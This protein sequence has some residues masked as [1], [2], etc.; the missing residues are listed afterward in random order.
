MV[1]L[2]QVSKENDISELR[3][4]M[5]MN[6]NVIPNKTILRKNKQANGKSQKKGTHKTNWQQRRGEIILETIVMGGT[7][8]L[9]LSLRALHK[10]RT[11]RKTLILRS[12]K[13]AY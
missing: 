8:D 11:H 6:H 13:S 7:K 2:I 1:R 3:N 10:E 9:R 5:L 4:K 12:L